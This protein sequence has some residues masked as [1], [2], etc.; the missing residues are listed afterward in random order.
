M[1]DTEK[2]FVSSQPTSRE[3]QDEK[4]LAK[5]K[6]KDEPEVRKRVVGSKPGLSHAAKNAQ[7]VDPLPCDARPPTSPVGQA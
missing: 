7:Q 1:C 6:F 3:A 2:G 4:R 5:L